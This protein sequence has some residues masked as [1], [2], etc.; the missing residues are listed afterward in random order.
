MKKL[1]LILALLAFPLMAS[2]ALFSRYEAVRQALLKGSFADVQKNA[3]ALAAQAK[4]AK[5][6]EVAAK[7][8]AVAKSADL[9]AART[10][11]GPL[12]EEMLKVREG[13]KGDRPSV[14]YCPMVKKSWLQPKGE[15]GNPYDSAM[16][17]CGMLK[18]E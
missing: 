5:Q 3:A 14:Y 8:E 1:I 12:S 13:A 6:A 18:S 11:F 10:A 4:T 2:P 9:A 15:V 17:K 16:E 7:A